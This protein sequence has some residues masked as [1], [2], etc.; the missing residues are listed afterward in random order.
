MSSHLSSFFLDP[1][2]D[3]ESSTCTGPTRRSEGAPEGAVGG[4]SPANSKRAVPDLFASQAV[5]M[6]ASRPSREGFAA[7]LSFAWL[8][9]FFIDAAGA[10]VLTVSAPFGVIVP[11]LSVSIACFGLADD[12]RDV[13]SRSGFEEGV[14]I[15]VIRTHDRI[16]CKSWVV[17]LLL[18]LLLLE[19]RPGGRAGRMDVIRRS[20]VTWDDPSRR[21]GGRDGSSHHKAGVVGSVRATA[22]QVQP[23]VGSVPPDPVGP[24][25]QWV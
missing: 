10:G 20:S 5:F 25:T 11:S 3:S 24:Y 16:E 9:D 13:D 21:T 14:D 6:R 1:S 23:C 18:L 7:L 2:F 4:V 12:D 15:D 19:G 22:T 8:A 17:L